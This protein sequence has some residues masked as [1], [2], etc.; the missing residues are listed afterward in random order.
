MDSEPFNPQESH[1]IKQ[2]P[3]APPS[4]IIQ[5]RTMDEA[6]AEEEIVLRGQDLDIEI[7]VYP[8]DDIDETD[9]DEKIYLV[10]IEEID[11]IHKDVLTKVGKLLYRYPNNGRRQYF[12]DLTRKASSDV[13]KFKVD[14]KAKAWEVKK[15]KTL[16]STAPLTHAQSGGDSDLRRRVEAIERANAIAEA[17]LEA[18]EAELKAAKARMM[19]RDK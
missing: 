16:I 6:A 1:L 5:S 18:A 9:V 15:A 12:E 3:I 10:K 2:P 4:R 14:V 11:R 8:P 17:E 19:E 13:R 7:Q